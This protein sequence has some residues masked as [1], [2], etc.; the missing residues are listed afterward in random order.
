MGH[1]CLT[2][3]TAAFI[4]LSSTISNQGSRYKSQ[5]TQI[6]G[7]KLMTSRAVFIYVPKCTEQH[8]TFLSFRLWPVHE[9][10]KY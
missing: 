8:R 1:C 9:L 2:D 6:Y 5:G 7:P 3:F 4:F 10:L